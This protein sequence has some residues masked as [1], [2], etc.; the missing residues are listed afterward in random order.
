MAGEWRTFRLGDVCS[1]IGSGATPRGGSGV[2][3]EHGDIALIRS[4]NIYN[5]G[6]HHDGIIYLTEEHAAASRW[7]STRAVT[8]T[9]TG[10]RPRIA[11]PCHCD[12]W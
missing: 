9:N 8:R 5:D 2:Y 4:Q 3:L 1:K 12:H 7:T 10:S 6:F 11:R